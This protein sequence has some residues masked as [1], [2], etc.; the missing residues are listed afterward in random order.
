MSTVLN[1]W[2]K[3]SHSAETEC[4]EVAETPH[5]IAIRDSKNP[6]G[7]VVTV[8]PGAFAEFVGYVGRRND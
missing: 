4:V 5:L 8:G 2:R 6:D 1:T 3:S 7:P